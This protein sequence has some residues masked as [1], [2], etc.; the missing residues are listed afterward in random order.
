MIKFEEIQNIINSEIEKLNFD[1]EPI[2]LYNPIAYVLSGHGKRLR[3]CLTLLSCNLFNDNVQNAIKPA[4]GIEIFHNFTLLHDD[5]MDKADLR[6]N[7]PTVH[8]KWNENVAI[9]S[10]D[11]MMIKAYE[12]FFDLKSE[13]L[14]K[15]LEVF[16]KSALQVCEGQQYDMNFESHLNVSADEYIKM[17]TLK[18]AVLLAASLKVGA[19]IGGATLKDTDLLYNFGLN[20]GIAF[21]LQDDYLDV[22]GDVKTF[23]KK[24]GGDIISNKKTFMLISA[25]EK[26][27]EI[28]KDK[29]LNLL[30]D[31]Y[32]DNAKKINEVTCIYNKLNIPDLIKK[33][34]NYYHNL[35][36]NNINLVSVNNDKKE[37]LINLSSKLLIREN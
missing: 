25:L 37:S 28:T 17:I 23:G 14:S 29:I 31:K 8:K 13:I 34:L 22:Y 30:N 12:F 36:I 7:K 19:I 1:I 3:P 26:A 9:L 21:Q 18:T 27:D 11:A 5:I 24:I 32:I 10:G 33:E 4:I 15:V 35:A 6:R 20:L 16:N 2:K